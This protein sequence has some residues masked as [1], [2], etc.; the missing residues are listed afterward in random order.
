[1]IKAVFHIDEPSKWNLLL[2]NAQNLVSEL[3]PASRQIAVVANSE[4]VAFYTAPDS[5][6]DGGRMSR[7]AAEGVQF[8]ACG[9]ALRGMG[10]AAE[11]LPRFVR[12]VPAGVLELAEKQSQ[13]YAYIKP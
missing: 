11:K 1:M 4:A 8:L 13:G 6:A 7:L 12:V 3:D 10:I 9:N 2:N 5:G